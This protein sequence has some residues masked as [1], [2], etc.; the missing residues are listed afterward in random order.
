[1]LPNLVIIGAARCGTTSLHVYLRDHPEVFM[2]RGKE[3]NFFREERN[4]HRGLAWYEQQFPPGSERIYGE[5]SVGYT[6]Y[7]ESPG[8]PERMAAVIPDARLVYLVRDP[9]E[10]AASEYEY[11]WYAGVETRSAA[12]AIFAPGPNRYVDRS[13]YAVQLDRFLA[14]FPPERILVLDQHGLMHERRATLAAVFRFLGVQDDFTSPAFDAV[15]NAG[16][17]HEHGGRVPSFR[18]RT[19][20]PVARLLRLAPV[21]ARAH[22]MPPLADPILDDATAVRLAELFAPDIGRLRALTG[23]RFDTWRI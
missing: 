23:L 21:R 9:V 1:V 11:M 5:S 14:H 20:K 10:R 15:H 6:S 17:R 3:L 2:A 7:P 12:T 8:V 22:L 16:R 13:R 19:A 18:A 4:W